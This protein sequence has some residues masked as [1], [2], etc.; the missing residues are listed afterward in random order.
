M[1]RREELINAVPVEPFIVQGK[2]GKESA[3]KHK[4]KHCPDSEAVPKKREPKVEVKQRI[5]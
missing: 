1:E 5:S 3:R 4:K 2:D